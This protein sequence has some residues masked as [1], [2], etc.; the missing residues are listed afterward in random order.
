MR[1]G[2]LVTLR[3][4]LLSS[5]QR[6]GESGLI[7]ETTLIT[8]RIGYPDA[9]FCRILWSKD[10]QTGLCKTEHLEEL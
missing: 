7:L 3:G 5:Y 1:V 2:D 10:N 4:G 9:E 6:E 8:N